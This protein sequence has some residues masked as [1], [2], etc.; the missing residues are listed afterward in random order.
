MKTVS[1]GDA[2][3]PAI[4]LGTWKSRKG[5]VYGA[6][7]EALHGGY[8]H[9]DC[10]PAYEN[11][12]EVGAALREMIGSGS[13]A[14]D[15]IWVTSKLWNNAHRPEDVSPALQKTLLDLQLDYLDLYLIHWPVAFKS[16]VF[17]PRSGKDYLPLA[18]VPL[19]ETWQALEECVSKGLTRFIG[20]CNFNIEKLEELINGG[21]TP[22]MM[23]QIELHPFLQQ[24]SMLDFCK[25]NSIL[26]TAYSPLGSPDRPQGLKKSDEP[27]LL[28]HP[29]ILSIA[30][31]YA[32]TAAQVLLAWGLWRDT[33]VIPKSVTPERIKVNLSSLDLKLDD[34]DL[35]EI[36]KLDMRY[37]YVDGTFWQIPGS[38]YTVQDIWGEK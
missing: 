35:R 5:D 30:E 12:E 28:E 29:V 38:G 16:D 32:V 37:R 19:L 36:G 3:I 11:E 27:L 8:R 22:P 15:S 17:F 13:V 4:G 1:Y 26:I 21:S 31:K 20:V 23:N 10:A 2:D 18:E 9:I 34:E 6:V 25:K 24:N 14:R 7:R 33:V